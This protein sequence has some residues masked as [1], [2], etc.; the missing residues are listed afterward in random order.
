MVLALAEGMDVRRFQ[1]EIGSL[2]G[3]GALIEAAAAAG[4]PA[5]SWRIGGPW[6]PRRIRRFVRQNAGRFDLIHTY[7]IRA[8]LLA[9]L[10]KAPLGRPAVICGI[11]ST[12]DGRPWAKIALDR[13]TQR[14]ADAFIANS[15]AGRLSRIARERIAP[16]RIMTIHNG[17]AA[18][19][20]LPDRQQAREAL[21][22]APRRFPVVAHVANLRPMK[23]HALALQAAS[24]LIGDFPQALF[25]F[26]GRDESKG[27]IERLAQAKGLAKNV[28]FLGFH[29]CP[30]EVLRAADIA[31]LPSDYEGC[32]V[33]ILEAM[34]EAMPI[35]ATQAGGIPELVRDGREALLIAAG[36]AAA[37]EAALRQMIAEEPLRRRLGEAAQSRFRAQFTL[38]RMVEQHEEIYRRVLAGQGIR[39][40]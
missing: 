17:L 2:G 18:A 36:D 14:R 21:H 22:I 6:E 10:L 16:E 9:R 35:V 24:R 40:G 32:P 19:H 12:D 1:V 25:V 28:V 37:L 4:I 8:D 38:Q 39:K 34:A 5:R 29:P 7:G 30:R 11:R 33:A 23:G 26:A 13:L 31:I 20:D 3:P 15:E 27:A